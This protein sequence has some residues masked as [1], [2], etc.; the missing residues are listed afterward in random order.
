METETTN[1]EYINKAKNFV[2][3][4]LDKIIGDLLVSYIPNPT[5]PI[6]ALIGFKIVDSGPK[7]N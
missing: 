7:F 4:E 5:F 3:A 6:I 2:L 1:Q